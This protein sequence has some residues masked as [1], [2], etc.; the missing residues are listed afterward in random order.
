MATD[1]VCGMFVEETESSLHAVVRGTTYYF[2]SETCMQSFVSPELELRSLKRMVALSAILS[3]P[4]LFLSYA[5]L[6]KTIPTSWILLALATPVQFVAGWRFYRGF[7]D[8][9]KMRASN[10]DVLIAIGTS[11]AYVYSTIYTIFPTSS[12]AITTAEASKY[13]PPYGNCSGKIV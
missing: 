7:W 5:A 8:A 2:C 12:S 6:P 4:I 9:V 1:P 11:A 13:S 3:V 10:M